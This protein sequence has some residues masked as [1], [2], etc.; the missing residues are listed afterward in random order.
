VGAAHGELDREVGLADTLPLDADSPCGESRRWSSISGSGSGAGADATARVTTR[1]S[2]GPGARGDSRS[3]AAPSA[4]ASAAPSGRSTIASTSTSLR[5]GTKS[6]SVSDP[7]RTTPAR[8]SPTTSAHAPATRSAHRTPS[9][10][11]RASGNE[12]EAATAA[13]YGRRGAGG[14]GLRAD[15]RALP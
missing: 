7:W 4:V 10:C 14:R 8:A 2:T 6:P 13:A 3:S 9:A 15:L 1:R 5:P 12:L 11:A